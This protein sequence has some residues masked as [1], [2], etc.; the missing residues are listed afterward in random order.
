MAK[1]SIIILTYNSSIHIASCLESIFDLYSLPLLNDEYELLI[2]DNAS[3][4]TTIHVLERFFE[5]H[6]KIRL[7]LFSKEREIQVGKNIRIIKN[8]GNYG[9]ARGMNQSVREATGEY[10]L[11]LNPDSEVLDANISE[12]V[13]ILESD[14]RIGI[15]CGKVL[16]ENARD[17]LTAGSFYN[18]FSLLLFVIGVEERVGV[19]YSPSE[20]QYIDF[21]SGGFMMVDKNIFRNLGG[22][23]ENFFM[24]IEDMELCFRMKKKGYATLFYPYATI[25]HYG[26]GS[27]DRTYAVIN[28]LKGMMYFFKKHRSSYFYEFARTLL[29]GK[30]YIGLFIGNLSHNMYLIRTYRKALSILL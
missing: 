5:T 27:S 3:S 11:F 24:Y 6:F 28:I 10:V 18:F 22:F 7:S 9:F 16:D 12:M 19:R 25:K 30:A 21:G 8:E 17:E 13:D 29:I 2:F 23:D 26:Q 4:D 20:K 14:E 1:L 15:V